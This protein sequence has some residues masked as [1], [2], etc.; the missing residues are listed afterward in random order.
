MQ[1]G[2][3]VRVYVHDNAGTA[4]SGRM[5][6]IGVHRDWRASSRTRRADPHQ[7]SR[8]TAF[9]STRSRRSPR[10]P[11]PVPRRP[12]AALT[13]FPCERLIIRHASTTA[14]GRDPMITISVNGSQALQKATGADQWGI[15]GPLRSSE[16]L[17]RITPWR[18]ASACWRAH[19]ARLPACR[20][21][22]PPCAMPPS[23][24]TAD[25]TA[26]PI[27]PE[28]PTPAAGSAFTRCAPSPHWFMPRGSARSRPSRR[29][30]MCF[31]A[32]PRRPSRARRHA[33]EPW[34]ARATTFASSSIA[35]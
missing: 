5:L 22:S 23:P 11:R 28:R 19:E 2:D 8:Q 1:P 26:F 20:N 17:Q 16:R 12:S 33:R 32:M 18:V 6:A 4:R 34:S 21:F 30:A 10:T 29:T 7:L 15:A 13:S 25:A 35:W 24:Q 27:F 31:P 14:C 9:L 3:K